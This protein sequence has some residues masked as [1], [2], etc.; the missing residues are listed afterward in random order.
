[1]SGRRSGHFVEDGEAARD[2]AGGGPVGLDDAGEVLPKTGVQEEII[3]ADL[4]ACFRKKV[5]K[6]FL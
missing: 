5:G 4:E 3:I 6:V 1:M 2:L